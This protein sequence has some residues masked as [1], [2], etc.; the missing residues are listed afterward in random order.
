MTRDRERRTCIICSGRFCVQT[1]ASLH[2]LCSSVFFYFSSAYLILF[3]TLWL[4]SKLPVWR[5][6]ESEKP[7]LNCFLFFIFYS[8]LYKQ[9]GFD[10]RWS[11]IHKSVARG[12]GSSFKGKGFGN[13]VEA[14]VVLYLFSLFRFYSKAW[15]RRIWNGRLEEREIKTPGKWV[16]PPKQLPEPIPKLRQTNTIPLYSY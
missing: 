14:D 6:N 16:L 4:T 11:F 9:R 1:S 15:K 5:E 13:I 12:G 3:Y 10:P 8:G 2:W 7:F